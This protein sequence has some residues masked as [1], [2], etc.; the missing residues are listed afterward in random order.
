MGVFLC[1][2]QLTRVLAINRACA[3][4]VYPSFMCIYEQIVIKFETLAHKIVIDCHIKFH[5][6][7]SYSSRDI[8]NT[9]L[10]FVQSLIF[11]AFSQIFIIKPLQYTNL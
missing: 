2:E 4:H 10:M 11:N 6:D 5:E 1:Q 9:I 7:P 3:A 8:C